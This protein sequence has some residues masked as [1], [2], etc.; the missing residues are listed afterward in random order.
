MSDQKEKL[1]REE[2]LPVPAAKPKGKA[3]WAIG[4]ILI[5]L[6][7]LLPDQGSEPLVS[8]L[9]EPA[10][11]TSEIGTASDYSRLKGVKHI[12]S[13]DLRLGQ[14][15]TVYDALEKGEGHLAR[16]PYILS[17]SAYSSQAL[18]IS[19]KEGASARDGQSSKG[20]QLF[21][22][23]YTDLNS[24]AVGVYKSMKATLYSILELTP[25]SYKLLPEN[26][27][28]W[29]GYFLAKGTQDCTA[30]IPLLDHILKTEESFIL[31][32]YDLAKCL[33][34]VG[35][36][37]KARISYMQSVSLDPKISKLLPDW[38]LQVK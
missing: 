12:L 23:T 25:H 27:L 24:N 19:L 20:S 13:L 26:E 8:L 5:V 21:N 3:V 16:T 31:G 33:E 36:S 1:E 32:W 6:Y 34:R 11:S 30:V 28:L 22:H 7:A 14:G 38:V 9:I 4:L 37:Q 2:L 18:E 15:V 10:K 29:D 17:M 35:E